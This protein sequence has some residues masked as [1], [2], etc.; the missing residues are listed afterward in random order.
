MNRKPNLIAIDRG[1]I[2]WKQNNSSG[3]S[4]MIQSELECLT[5]GGCSAITDPFSHMVWIEPITGKSAEE[6]YTKFVEG[7]LLEEGA[8]LC[9]LTDNGR[10]FDNKLL[11]ELLR[12]LKIR[13]YLTPAYH[14]RGNY[15]ERVNGFI[16]EPLRTMLSMSGAKKTDWWELAKFIQF[17]YRTGQPT[18]AP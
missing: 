10:E 13:S 14:P 12:L 18:G 9:I 15:T 11:M 5:N 3:G 2:T 8:P 7:F 17:A 1:N 6:V 4:S 16:G